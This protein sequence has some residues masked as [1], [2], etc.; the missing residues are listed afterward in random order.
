MIVSHDR[1]FLNTV[2]TDIIHL[3]HKKLT[4][5]KGDY[6]SFERTRAEKRRNDERSAEAEEMKRAHIQKFIDRF[7]FNA[8]RASLVQS[9]IKALDKLGGVELLDAVCTCNN[10]PIAVAGF[11]FFVRYC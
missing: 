6:D 2:V 4:Y 10:L 5:Y 11:L 8:K 9:R 3:E 1:R 7:R